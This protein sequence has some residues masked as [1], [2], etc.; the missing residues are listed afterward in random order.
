VLAS[1]SLKHMIDLISQYIRKNGAAT[2]S[3]LRQEL[4]CSRR[5]I[6]PLLEHLDRDGLTLRNGDT[7]RLRAK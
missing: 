2:V 7:R 1:D 6:V 3:Q 5:V 4:G